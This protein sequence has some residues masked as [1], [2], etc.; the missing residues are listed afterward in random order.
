MQAGPFEIDSNAESIIKPT[1][2]T[3]PRGLFGLGAAAV[4]VESK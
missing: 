2:L 1:D 3:Q 4:K